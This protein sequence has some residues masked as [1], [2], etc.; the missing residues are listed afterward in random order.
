MATSC[1]RVYSGVARELGL[2]QR[3]RRVV[4]APRL[5]GELHVGVAQLGDRARQLVALLHRLAVPVVL[6]LEERDAAPLERPRDDRE[7]LALHRARAGKG[8]ADLAHVVAVHHRGLPS[9][10]VEPL[11]VDVDVVL[12]HRRA[13]LAEAVD[14]DDR[15]Q[16]VEPVEGR[17]LRGF[18]H[19][20][21]GRLA[22]AEERVD[23]ARLA[24][25]LAGPGH[26]RCRAQPLAERPRGH[27]HP[28]DQRSGMPLER[29]RDLAQGEQVVVDAARLLERGPQQRRG[30]A[31]GQDEHVGAAAAGVGGVVAH[32]VEEEHGDDVR[33][34]H[35]ARGMARPGLR[36]GLEGMAAQLLR[37]A[38][39]GGV[40][41][42]HGG[43]RPF[44]RGICGG[45]R[46]VRGRGDG[47]ATR[48]ARGRLRERTA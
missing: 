33:R 9:E 36:R 34:R 10:G 22:V 14:V 15:A 31:L 2:G 47:Q 27:A 45:P 39:E 17:E 6:V 32:L 40:V 43:G 35:A 41:H 8:V 1:P 30:V 20:A 26:P 42:G 24:V 12:V 48:R 4:V 44:C 25:A 19:R 13:A 29:A 3:L 5:Y 7:R 23:A 16:V 46:L 38:E 21:L 37:H 18:P 28:G 11:L